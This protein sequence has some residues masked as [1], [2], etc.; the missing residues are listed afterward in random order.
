MSQSHPPFSPWASA[1]AADQA[2]PSS[3]SLYRCPSL[4]FP[5]LCQ[6]WDA[7][8]SPPHCLSSDMR[9]CITLALCSHR[10]RVT[11][12][13]NRGRGMKDN[14]LGS[15][16]FWLTLGECLGRSLPPIQSPVKWGTCRWLRLGGLSIHIHVSNTLR[17][18]DNRQNNGP[19]FPQQK[20]LK[21][22]YS[23]LPV[24]H[25]FLNAIKWFLEVMNGITAVT[26]WHR[27]I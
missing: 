14:L 9:L 4:L 2:S 27:N 1:H 19:M 10:E 22:C 8:P 18:R 25:C 3:P 11:L 24:P 12:W 17:S 16:T 21:T 7:I 15:Q 26:T 13:V 20:S 6:Q 5:H 23:S